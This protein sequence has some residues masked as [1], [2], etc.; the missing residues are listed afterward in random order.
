ML[1]HWV[2]LLGALCVGSLG[3]PQI[4]SRV[5]WKASRSGCLKTLRK[6]VDTAVVHHTESAACTSS[7]SCRRQVKVI[8]DFHQGPSK[9]WCDIGYNFLIGE[10]GQVYEGRGWRTVGA[11][12]GPG[13]NG[14]SLGIAF[15]GSFKSRVP[16]AKAQAALKSLLSCAVQRGSLGSDYVLKGHRDVVATSCPG[17]ALYDVIRHWP[18]FKA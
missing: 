9:K 17:Q 1:W 16:N 4:V 12:A 8:Q 10:D 13:W 2:T 3:C 5:Q 14:R 7:V 6:P 11:H 15:L 18:H